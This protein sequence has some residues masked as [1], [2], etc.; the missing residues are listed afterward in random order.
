[1][2]TVP[3]KE[4][5]YSRQISAP[6]LKRKTSRFGLGQFLGSSGN[7]N[8]SSSTTTTTTIANASS[9]HVYATANY[10]MQSSQHSRQHSATPTPHHNLAVASNSASCHLHAPSNSQ[11][12]LTHHSHHAHYNHATL[13]A[14]ISASEAYHAAC[15][16]SAVNQHAHL[17]QTQ[18]YSHT[19]SPSLGT[20][21]HS[22]SHQYLVHCV[23]PTHLHSPMP[24]LPETEGNTHSR[25]NTHHATFAG[26]FRHSAGSNASATN[27]HYPHS[28][29]QKHPSAPNLL[30]PPSAPA[31]SPSPSASSYPINVAHCTCDVGC[32]SSNA[33][34]AASASVAPA[35][36]G[37][38]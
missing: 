31:S 15:S 37:R 2:F 35:A 26:I 10:A 17:T 34:A 13:T 28:H 38:L 19:Y 3:E 6:I 5:I 9:S 21:L 1:M 20:N 29:F 27:F 14:S 25:A 4:K 16:S 33:A 7:H 8:S 22:Q 12:H 30:P 23:P 32:G 36:Q 18:S 24:T 11:Q